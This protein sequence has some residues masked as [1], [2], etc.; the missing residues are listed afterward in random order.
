MQHF[1]TVITVLALSVLTT[2]SALAQTSSQSGKTSG[3]FCEENAGFC[4]I[5]APVIVGIIGWALASGGSTPSKDGTCDRSTIG[6]L[7]DGTR[8]PTDPD[9]W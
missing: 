1:R 2:T 4:A 7:P 9:C 8:G 3:G 6:K 5:A